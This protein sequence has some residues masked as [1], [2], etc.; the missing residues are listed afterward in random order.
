MEME[1]ET[2]D[3][4]MT[5]P[6][7]THLNGWLRDKIKPTDLCKLLALQQKSRSAQTKLPPHHGFHDE[8]NISGT[9]AYYPGFNGLVANAHYKVLHTKNHSSA[10]MNRSSSREV[11]SVRYCDT[12]FGHFG[13]FATL[14]LRNAVLASQEFS[15]GFFKWAYANSG[16]DHSSDPDLAAFLAE[17][18]YEDKDY[19][20]I[21]ETRFLLE[22]S[23]SLG[24]LT[25]QQISRQERKI[26]REGQKN[27]PITK[28][29]TRIMLKAIT[30]WRERY[31]TKYPQWVEEFHVAERRQFLR[32]KYGRGEIS[33]LE[34]EDGDIDDD[35]SCDTES[36]AA[37]SESEG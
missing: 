35:K 21:E 31:D 10:R 19:F 6:T 18:Q 32:Q 20:T 15:L 11:H 37:M 26:I 28:E 2:A 13:R 3:Q 9:Y 27:T 16:A 7:S 36:T 1:I 14:P 12:F 30:F 25:D 8:A 24:R 22:V 5:K 17:L 4:M 33:A 29:H 34:L 23:G